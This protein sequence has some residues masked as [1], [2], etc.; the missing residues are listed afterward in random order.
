[1][2]EDTRKRMA[3]S[4]SAHW[5]TPTKVLDPVRQVNNIALD[6]CSNLF[7]IVEP[8]KAVLL[9]NGED[10]LQ[11]PWAELAEDLGGLVYVNP[12]Y[13]KVIKYW[14]QKCVIESA[15]GAE[16]IALVGARTETKWFQDWIMATAQAV[17]FWKGRLTFIDGTGQGRKN[18]AFFPSAVVYWG[19]NTAKFLQ[20][21][22]D[23]G[24][25]IPLHFLRGNDE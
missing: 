25:C 22:E 3:S 2:D 15:R 13:G 11:L 23:K 20:E 1:M 9:E 12:P 16:I 10:G 5:C 21:F 17:C 6:P 18:P 14:I 19:P 7:S 24:T 8:K 4:K